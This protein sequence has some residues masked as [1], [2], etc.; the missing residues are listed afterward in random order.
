MNHLRVSLDVIP[1]V[2]SLILPVLCDFLL[3]VFFVV[4]VGECSK[5]VSSLVGQYF[6][7]ISE[8]DYDISL[9]TQAFELTAAFSVLNILLENGLDKSKLSSKYHDAYLTAEVFLLVIFQTFAAKWLLL[10]KYLCISG[11]T[12]IQ[13]ILKQVHTNSQSNNEAGD[14]GSLLKENM[15][16]LTVKLLQ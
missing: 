12:E 2:N 6:S 9:Q 16:K 8:E 1:P 4:G 13:H 3:N 11:I 15:D 14:I 10:Y 5:D 7:L